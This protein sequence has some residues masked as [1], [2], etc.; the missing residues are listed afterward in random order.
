MRRQGI[1]T[2]HSDMEEFHGEKRRLY[3]AQITLFR[4]TSQTIQQVLTSLGVFPVFHSAVLDFGHL[5]N[6]RVRTGAAAS[7]TQE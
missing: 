1:P 2:S 7:L 5:D 4:K 3:Q 6:L